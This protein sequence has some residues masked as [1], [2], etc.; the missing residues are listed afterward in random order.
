MAFGLA[1]WKPVLFLTGLCLALTAT[2]AR[3]EAKSPYLKSKTNANGQFVRIEL[4]G[5]KRILTLAEVEVYS[6]GKNIA[7]T[8]KATQSSIG[9]GGAPE[10]AIDGNKNPSYG[11]NGQTH[12]SEQKNPWW[13]L[14]LGK[15]TPIN[16]ISIW[17]RAD[18]LERRLDGFTLQVLDK[19]RKKVFERMTI[20][21]PAGAVHLRMEGNGNAVYQTHD[22]KKA[23]PNDW[24]NDRSDAVYWTRRD[25]VAVPGDY[26]DQLPFAFQKGDTIAMIG[27]ALGERFQHHGDIEVPVQS[28]LPGMELAFRNMCLSGDQID[29]FPRSSGFT[30]MDAYLQHVAPDVIFCFFGYNESYEDN[31]GDYTKRLVNY[32]RTL[33]SYQPNGETFPRIVLF[34]PIAHENLGDPN[35]PKGNANNRRLAKY[36]EATRTAAEQAGVAFVDLFSETKKLYKANKEPLTINGIH[37]NEKGGTLVGR[38]IAKTL[39]G[40]EPAADS[41]TVAKLT[42][43]KNWHWF[44]RYRATDGNDIWGGRSKLKFVNDQTN[45][46]VLQHELIM[47]DQMVANRDKAIW[48]A[49]KGESP[50]VSDGNVDAPVPV[51]SN[52]GGGSK[53]SNASKEGS[54]EYLSGTEGVDKF[55]TPDGYKVNLFADEAMFPEMV[56]PVQMQVDGKGRIWAAVWP[57][58]PKWEPLKEM[59]DAL[60]ILEDTDGDGVAD[61]CKEFAKVHNPLGF[62]FW[63]GGVL[64]TS[65]PDLIFLKDTDGDDVADE[66]HVILHGFG[67]SDTHHTANNLIYGPDGGIYWQSGVFLVHNHEHPWGAPLQTGA[68]AMFRWDPRRFTVAYHAA[69]SPN[70]HGIAFDY[71]GYHYANDGTGGRSYQVRPDEHGFKMHMLLNKEVRPVAADAIVSSE[72][73]P[74]EVQGN[75]LVCNTI[76]FLGLKNYKLHRDGYETE[77]TKQVKVDGKRKNVKEMVKFKTGEVWGTPEE[78]MLVSEDGNFRPTDAVFGEDGA[79]Y[80]SDWS[81][82]IIGHMQHNI[83]DPNRDHSHGRIYRMVYEDRPLQKPVAIDG[84]PLDQLMANL[85]HP[86]NGVRHRTRVELSERD[87]DEVIAAAKKWLAKWDAKNPDHAHHL[88][89]GLWV[90]QQHNVRDMELLQTVLDS[91]VEHARIAAATVRHHW[92]VADPAKGAIEIEEEEEMEITPGGVISDTP[93]LTTLRVNTVVEQLRYDVKE[94]EVK[95]GKQVK[96]VFANPDALPHNLVIVK[97]G[98]ADAVAAAAIAMGADGF[99]KQFIP[100]SSDILHHT[101]MLEIGQIE[102]LDFKAPTTPGDYQFVCTFPGHATIMRGVL[103]VK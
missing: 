48:A 35:L 46:E 80:V 90:H 10:R 47:I 100:A 86:I 9:S 36:T 72:N 40:K 85:E 24:K 96:L 20:A 34:S 39:T 49:A 54:L 16:A 66:R 19:D 95:A 81:N 22:G 3:A 4:L 29:K 17:N 92:E 101:A 82:V 71:W 32:V 5:A 25:P 6:S 42:A 74:P 76:G 69:N 18:G 30:P 83:R 84:E 33:R 21:A 1:M 103:R 70:P 7:A 51:I 97:P 79:L 50:V 55:T 91:P 15:E 78:D 77:V 73:F 2:E 87:S 8:G 27:N 23:S 89:E 68:S 52:V 62:E 45:A 28:A 67:S 98:T 13:E 75:F 57:T 99:K 88:L 14:D 93:E 11:G 31:P 63:N 56:N 94:L 38:Y 41:A 37:L 60:V 53:S 102:D 64:V 59:N 43:D 65:Q 12:T 58:Y 26:K 44:N 61:K